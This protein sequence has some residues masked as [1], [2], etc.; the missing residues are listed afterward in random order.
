MLGI[1]ESIS[2][3]TALLKSYNNFDL[4]GDNKESNRSLDFPN[5][6]SEN[7]YCRFCRMHRTEM[8]TATEE[9]IELRRTEDNYAEDVV[10]NEMSLT[11]VKDCSIFNKV[12]YFHVVTGSAN[13]LT[14]DLLEGAFPYSHHGSLKC[15]I[16]DLSKLYTDRNLLTLLIIES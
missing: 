2:G 4:L 8:A 13:D 10:T 3:K 7:C 16:F 6:H 9:I 11:V 15:L 14:H 12:P 1:F 5:S